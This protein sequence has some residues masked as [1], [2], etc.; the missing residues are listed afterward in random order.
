MRRHGALLLGLCTLALAGCFSASS[1]RP[2]AWLDHLHPFRSAPAPD[3]IQLDVALIEC[4]VGDKFI[5]EGIWNEVDEEVVALDR[6][7]VLD[8]N[9]FRVGQLGEVMPSHLQVLLNSER[10]CAVK[11]RH[12]V[13]AGEPV[14][15]VLG[16]SAADCRFELHANNGKT[17][18]AFPDAQCWL[19]IDATA[20][21]DGSTRLHFTPFVEHGA[22]QAVMR[23]TNDHDGVVVDRQRAT[24]D[25]TALAWD[26]TVA[27]N[28]FAVVGTHYSRPATLGYQ[29]FFRPDEARPVQRLLVIWPTHGGQSDGLSTASD[30]TS[31]RRTVAP[32][33]EQA[34]WATARGR[35]ND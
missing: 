9:G 32:I 29:C 24:E 23:P 10:T 6:K 3:V 19:R 21:R 5:N 33:A 34:G 20:D 4:P 18:M 12:Q 15:L 8:D 1:V 26:V 7:A 2:T 27:H 25:Y 16:P 13:R 22:R 28:R 17:P 14:R 11:R 30:M 35:A 31:G